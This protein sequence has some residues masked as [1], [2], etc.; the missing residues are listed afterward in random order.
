MIDSKTID[1][2]VAEILRQLQATGRVELPDRQD[3]GDSQF[4]DITSSECRA[5][6]LLE[7]PADP[8]V[9]ER[10]LKRTTARIGVGK[11]GA[12]AKNADHVD[13]PGGSCSGTG[14]RI[15]RRGSCIIEVYGAIYGTDLVS[16]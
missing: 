12:P 13:T 11:A 10:M 14:C 9:L 4:E 2:I 6:P 3:P 5:V 15:R 8:E 7:H 1:A 16:G